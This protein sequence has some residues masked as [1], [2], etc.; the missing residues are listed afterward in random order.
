VHLFLWDIDM[1]VLWSGGAGLAAMNLAFA[2]L[3]GID[4]AYADIEFSGRTDLSLFREALVR[5]GLATEA[6]DGAVARYE[7]AYVR[8]LAETLTSHAGRVLPGVR[9]VLAILG[10]LDV[11]A[12]GVATGNFRRGAALKLAYYGVDDHLREGGYGSDAEQ[13][14]A[15]VAIAAQRLA[16]THAR[17]DGWESVVVIG[18]SPLDVT[19]ARANGFVAVGVATGHSDVVALS[20]AGADL[21]L[22]D[23]GDVDEAVDA[24]LAAAERAAE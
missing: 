16:A 3:Y 21:V 9:E 24:L 8:H 5:H 4:Q 7:A 22:P 11:V 6:F 14:P 2:E 12:Q 1:T 18:D 17:P 15:I 13:R 10:G 20:R 19:A 23:L